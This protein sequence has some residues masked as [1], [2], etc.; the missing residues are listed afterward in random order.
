[1]GK[2]DLLSD[3]PRGR[4]GKTLGTPPFSY[5]E[6]PLNLAATKSLQF[7]PRQNREGKIFLGVTGGTVLDDPHTGGRAKRFVRGGT[8]LGILDD[9]HHLILAGS[10]SGKGRAVLLPNLYLAPANASILCV[11]PKGENTRLSAEYR[12]SLQKVAVLD[13]TGA[14]GDAATKYKA[15]FNPLNM[16][17]RC[18]RWRMVPYA[19]VI[20]DSL[21]VPGDF[22]DRH[23][24][25]TSMSFLAALVVHVATWQRYEKCRDLV[26]VRQLITEASSPSAPG[27]KDRWLE[28]EML[29]N[30][31]ASNFV[32]NGATQFYQRANAEYSSVLSTLRKHTEFL[33]LEFIQD[34]ICGDGIDLRDL[35]RGA[36]TI[37]AVV[38]AMM[39]STLSG[40]LRMLVQ[41]SIAAHEQER[42]QIGPSSLLM[43]D[44]FSAIGRLEILEV[45]AAQIAGL[46]AKLMPVIQDLSQLKSKY[47]KSYETFIANAGGCKYLGSTTT[48]LVN[49]HLANSAQRRH[50]HDRRTRLRLIKPRS[51]GVTGESWAVSNHPLLDPEEVS[52]FFARDDHKLRQ[53][54]LRPGFRPAVIQRAYYDKHEIFKGGAGNE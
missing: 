51:K 38:E 43:I 30:T 32:R 54:I 42:T 45:A 22:K 40:W 53:L 20:A 41:L 1:M 39:M 50:S 37:Y 27:G 9:R 12:A 44:E 17:A 18:E 2:D 31:T 33:D 35:K 7:E 6:L 10:R 16:V 19:R 11:D 3:L 8:T 13:P 28:T 14:S 36:L 24:D 25:V 29:S 15:S 46:G 34:S 49:T 47:P 21:I 26:T 52:R 48:R 5:F 23:W 4:D